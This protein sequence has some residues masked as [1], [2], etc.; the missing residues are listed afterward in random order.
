M[1]QQYITINGTK[2]RQPDEGLGYDFETTFGED[3]KRTQL[4]QLMTSPVF[5]VESLSYTASNVTA[6]EMKT[7]LQLVMK[8]TFFTLHYWSPFYGAW[9][10]DEFYVGRGTLAIGRLNETEEVYDTLSFN[11]VGRNPVS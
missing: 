5:T 6:D 1:A 8:G 10:D 7:I 4:G 2:I 9:R 3:S 11:M